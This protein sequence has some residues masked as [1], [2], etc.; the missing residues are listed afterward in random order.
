[1]FIHQYPD[2]VLLQ[3]SKPVCKV[4]AELHTVIKQMFDIVEHLDA[5][6][7]AANQIGIPYRFFIASKYVFI[8]PVILHRHGSSIDMEGCLSLAGQFTVRR[9][10]DIE[11]ATYD[12]NGEYKT[13]HFSGLLARV[14][15][16]EMDHLNGRLINAAM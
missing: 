11:V 9:A 7:L 13:Y 14:V 12:L 5:L 3:K 1:M 15:Q 6:G 10:T 2:H 8:N 4:D 16:H